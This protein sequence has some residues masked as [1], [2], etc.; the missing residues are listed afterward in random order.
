MLK[1]ILLLLADLIIP[2]YII[3]SDL[4]GQFE[5]V[6][7]LSLFPLTIIGIIV[8]AVTMLIVRRRSHAYLT[9]EKLW[10]GVKANIFIIAVILF[11]TLFL[12]VLPGYA[13]KN[14]APFY[15]AYLKNTAKN[16][17]KQL[18]SL[19]MEPSYLPP[20]VKFTIKRTEEESWQGG[21]NS[22]STIY[23]CPELNKSTFGSISILT[24]PSSLR[25]YD[26]Q[27]SE[28]IKISGKKA[29]IVR[30]SYLVLY[31]KNITRKIFREGNC[32]VTKEDLV[33]IMSS[34][35]PAQFIPGV[36]QNYDSAQPAQFIPDVP[37]TRNYGSMIR[38]FD[39]K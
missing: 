32:G 3:W 25:K 20:Q 11:W 8:H 33:K 22:L 35:Q 28:T 17:L 6:G 15:D 27:N 29:V 10:N 14:I 12:I 9:Q 18:E 19:Y 23:V 13:V 30:D 24:S 38:I 39:D 37:R 26:T 7:A 31:D 36:Q 2:V 34:L 4:N 21:Y 5:S 16:D 1:I